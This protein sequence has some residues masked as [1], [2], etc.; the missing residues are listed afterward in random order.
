LILFFI[1]YAKISFQCPWFIVTGIFEIKKCQK[2]II[3]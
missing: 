2:Y 1:F 3:N